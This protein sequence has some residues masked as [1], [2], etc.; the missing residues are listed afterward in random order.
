MKQVLL[1]GFAL[2]LTAVGI[3]LYMRPDAPAKVTNEAPVNKVVS[4]FTLYRISGEVF[5][6]KET[7]SNFSLLEGESIELPNHTT[8]KT[9]VGKAT[10]LLDDRSMIT[11]K[12]NTQIEV[13]SSDGGF[14]IMQF[15]G[16]TYHRVETLVT[17]KTYEVRT[18]TTLAAVRGTKFAV[19][20]DA[21]KKETKVAVTEHRVAINEIE[22]MTS[23][24]TIIEDS[25]MVEEGKT[26]TYVPGRTG[27]DMTMVET[28]RDATMQNLI[29]EEVVMDEVYE[30]V[31]Q[32]ET[33]EDFRRRVKDILLKEEI[34]QEEKRTEQ[35]TELEKKETVPARESLEDG[36]P[37]KKN[38][39]EETA[40]TAVVS[41]PVK[42]MDE[43]TFFGAFEPLFIK[44]FYM[45]EQHTPCTFRGTST[46]RVKQVVSFANENGYPFTS[47]SKL[48]VFAED[49][50]KFCTTKD[51]ALYNE[52][53]QRFDAEYPYQ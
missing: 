14:D 1:F 35:K 27:T 15:F 48:G 12:E 2:I 10:V 3:G 25:T 49:I 5:Y 26:L 39:N 6:K 4:L 37:I 28:K 23:T 53:Q 42:K 7:D 18:P 19:F 32:S 9:T 50:A 38:T 47:T 34:R 36:T 44:L 11:L 33:K 17:G 21:T 30:D 24:S 20:Y 40:P 31:K 41:S 45:D 22:N 46:E 52:L 29:N 51:K 43:E 13:V 16:T 8:V